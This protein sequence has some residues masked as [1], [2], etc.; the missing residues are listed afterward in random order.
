MWG[1]GDF[2]F[3]ESQHPSGGYPDRRLQKGGNSEYLTGGLPVKYLGSSLK[4]SQRTSVGTTYKFPSLAFW[5]PTS[6]TIGFGFKFRLYTDFSGGCSTICKLSLKSSQ[7]KFTICYFS[8]DGE[9]TM[10]SG[11]VWAILDALRTELRWISLPWH[12]SRICKIFSVIWG[13]QEVSKLQNIKGLK[14]QK[15]KQLQHL[16]FVKLGES[17]LQSSQLII[18]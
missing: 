1:G 4:L 12:C 16:N 18:A 17:I 10:S 9:G 8:T 7:L 3:P 14:L 5:S 13:I 11:E 6:I 2:Q 15:V